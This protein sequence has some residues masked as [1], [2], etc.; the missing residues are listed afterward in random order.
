MITYDDFINLF[1]NHWC[2][3]DGSFG[4]QCVDFVQFYN[5][6]IGNNTPFW[7]NAKD[8]ASQAGTFYTY[9]L[10]TPTAIPSKGDIIVWN[11]SKPYTGGNGHTA[12]ANGEA[13]LSMFKA[14]SQNDPTGSKVVLNTYSDNYAYVLGWLHPKVLPT[15]PVDNS[16]KYVQA[17]QQIKGVVSQVGI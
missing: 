1:I 17:L 12:I 7:G 2:D 14:Y 5:K 15:A 4:S 8:L 13:T 16:Q 11:G 9:I 6:S 10:N 3:W